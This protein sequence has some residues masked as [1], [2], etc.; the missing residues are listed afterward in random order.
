MSGRLKRI[1]WRSVIWTAVAMAAVGGVLLREIGLMLAQVGADAGGSGAY[2]PD[3]FSAFRF[4]D[5]SGV[6]FTVWSSDAKAPAWFHAHVLVDTVVFAPAVYLLLSRFLR[7]SG[8]RTTW[9]TVVLPAVAFGAD[10]A[11]NLVALAAFPNGVGVLGVILSDAKWVLLVVGVLLGILALFVRDAGMTVSGGSLTYRP[12]GTEADPLPTRLGAVLRPQLWLLVL[13]LAFVFLVA[14]PGGGPLDQLPDVIRAQSARGG[15]PTEVG[16]LLALVLLAGATVT[17][18]IRADV[19][20]RTPATTMLRN[21]LV[22]LAAGLLGVLLTLVRWVSSGG[23]SWTNAGAPFAALITCVLVAVAGT[24]VAGLRGQERPSPPSPPSAADPGASGSDGAVIGALPA[25]VLLGGAV[26]LARATAREQAA[27]LTFLRTLGIVVVCVALGVALAVVHLAAARLAAGTTRTRREW[28]LLG[29]CPVVALAWAVVLALHPEWAAFPRSNGTVALAVAVVAVLLGE[30]VRLGRSGRPWTAFRDL[31]FRGTPWAGLVVASWVLAGL[32]TP[33]PDYHLVRTRPG[34]DARAAYRYEGLRSAFDVW[35]REVRRTPACAAAGTV[36]LVL[37][38]APGG[39]IRAAQWTAAGLEL[40]S[41]GP[42]G[43]G[44]VF[45]VSGVSG[46]SVGTT[47]W[48]ATRPTVP[49]AGGA[50]PETAATRAVAGMA[51]DRALSAA[52][53]GLFLRDPLASVTGVGQEGWRDRAAVMED[54]LTS[55]PGS[56]LGTPGRPASWSEVSG[57]G[58]WSPVL[59]LNAHSVTDGCRVLVTNTRNLSPGRADC[60][61]APGP[62]GA[63]SP[64][65]VPSSVDARAGLVGSPP[66][67]VG[68]GEDTDAGD[69]PSVR[70]LPAVTGGLIPARFPV[71]SPTAGIQQCLPRAPGARPE[72]STTYAVD[73]G[74]GENSGLGSLLDLAEALRPIIAEARPGPRV[75]VRIVLLDNHYRSSAIASAPKR[76]RELLAPLDA[77]LHRGPTAGGLE[78]QADLFLAQQAGAAPPERELTVLA[79]REGAAVSAPLGWV[80]SRETSCGL[81]AQMDD[82]WTGPD[83]SGLRAALRIDGAAPG[84]AAALRCD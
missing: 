21:R 2:T 45:A 51:E 48:S 18:G 81:M 9:A 5:S 3:A 38:A 55:T 46:G 12:R 73:G 83:S 58:G 7:V 37:V 53:A 76:P 15:V 47:V 26:G 16:P 39:G 1:G 24:V 68:A 10:L 31:G 28:V 50:A 59:V 14:F 78:Q 74:Y 20:F 35:D 75:A 11:E 69:G 17:A 72:L 70:D 66:P 23:P 82:E 64:G 43:A 49:P 52:L 56:G 41:S 22:L 27:D 34:D 65:A 77:L 42:C 44:P 30:L 32:L 33:D 19:A 8:V 60:Q 25:L 36:P 4:Q 40:L 63:G 62:D 84:R 13:T 54:V 71:V 57:R 80:L 29:V 67:C 6:A 61:A 79:P